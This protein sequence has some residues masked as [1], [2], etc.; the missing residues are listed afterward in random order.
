MKKD[1]W[2]NFFDH[3]Y[4]ITDARSVCDANLTSREVD[5][6]EKK[7][8]LKKDDR[9]L[10]LFGGQGRHSIE[11]AKRGYRDL[12]VLDYSNYLINLGKKL[13]KK[14]NIKVDFQQ[15]DARSTGLKSIDYSVIIMMANS[16]GYFPEDRENL[17]V[18]REA[19]RLLKT[20]GKLFIDLT[21]PVYVRKNLNPMSWHKIGDIYVLRKRDITNN[22]VKTQEIVISQKDGLLRDESYCIC[23]FSKGRIHQQLKR[24]GFN[25][26]KIQNGVFL[27]N[28]KEDCGLITSRMIIQATKLA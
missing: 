12:T 25:K 7:V 10:D 28:K 9:I 23:L 6:L 1:W 21:D 16:F 3:I 20:K 8:N 27:H 11:L 19:N 24:A 15:G 4:L 14:E 18:L 26:I 13:A 17:Q 22:L 5:L 2:K